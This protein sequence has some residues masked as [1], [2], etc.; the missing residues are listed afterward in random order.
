M[1]P[2]VA[3]RC[4][5]CSKQR[6]HFRL[7]KVGTNGQTICD[8]CLEWHAHNLD[9]LGGALPKGCQECG[10]TWEQLQEPDGLVAGRIFIVPKDGI[11]QA[12]CVV[13]I[14]PYTGK[15]ADLYR[16]TKFGNE[17]LKL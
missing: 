14:A 7:L 16:D 1:S 12:L 9:V 8:Y 2:I 15:R 10:R 17:T 4:N 13:C 11:Y 5:F 3:G 6:P